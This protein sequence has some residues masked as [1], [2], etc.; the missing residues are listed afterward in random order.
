MYLLSHSL[1]RTAFS[2]CR[3]KA[4]RTPLS[5][6]EQP[7]LRFCRV[8]IRLLRSHTG[9][10]SLICVRIDNR[11]DEEMAS[12]IT[13]H[14]QT[15]GTMNKHNAEWKRWAAAAAL[16]GTLCLY[17]PES[18]T[19]SSGRAHAGGSTAQGTAGHLVLNGTLGQSAI[20]PIVQADRSVGQGF[21]YRP[22]IHDG[23]STTY[24]PPSTGEAGLNTALQA[25]PNPFSESIAVTFSLVE[26]E[27]ISI[28][29]YDALGREVRVVLDGEQ[30]SGNG[31]VMLNATD[32]P[33]GHYTLVSVIGSEQQHLPLQ[34]IR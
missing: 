25:H 33:S 4:P 11:T 22:S 13:M 31:R 26:R 34:L 9:S 15:Y 12:F 8:D 10:K 5:P 7:L 23:S 16:I 3:F 21:W 28:R 14:N 19:Q 29:L 2:H 30:P 20:G 17:P 24:S 18:R 1:F 6:R 32:L 27:R